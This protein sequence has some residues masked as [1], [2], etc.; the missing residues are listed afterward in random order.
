MHCAEMT[1]WGR[2]LGRL[3]CILTAAFWNSCP[4]SSVTP[5]V[6]MVLFLRPGAASAHAFA[7]LDANN[8]RALQECQGAFS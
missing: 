4:L 7:S 8:D 2:S 5:G 1:D 3:P 6:S